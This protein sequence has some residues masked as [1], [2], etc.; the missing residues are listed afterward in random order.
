M[1]LSEEYHH[2]VVGLP[3]QSLAQELRVGVWRKY[4]GRA[5]ADFSQPPNV[6]LINPIKTEMVQFYYALTPPHE[7]EP[8][9][10]LVLAFDER[11]GGSFVNVCTP[12]FQQKELESAQSR[13]K[14]LKELCPTD[15]YTARPKENV[16]V[17]EY[18]RRKSE[19]GFM[20][21]KHTA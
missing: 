15:G 19:S 21:T 1:L 13:E 10:S 17:Q 18:L 14:T 8:K 11:Y 2:A 3:A 6:A 4:F 5:G 12:E 16:S 20:L 7:T 9:A